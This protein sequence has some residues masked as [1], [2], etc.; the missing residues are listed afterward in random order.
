MDDSQKMFIFGGS[1]TNT[2]TKDH[3]VIQD[4]S[5][6]LYLVLFFFFFQSVETIAI[7]EMLSIYQNE[8]ES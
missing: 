3:E 6:P 1:K 2:G 5:A 8:S 7:S 4:L